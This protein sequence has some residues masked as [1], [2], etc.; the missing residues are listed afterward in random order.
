[1]PKK[2]LIIDDDT[3]IAML[4]KEFFSSEGYQTI[5]ATDGY[6]GVAAAMREKPDL[7]ILD[8]QMPAGGGAGVFERLSTNTFL[9]TTPVIF[10]TSLSKDIMDKMLPQNSM[11]HGYF[12]KP[13]DLE[14]LLK[15]IESIIGKP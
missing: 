8:M 13:A 5:T 9:N 14:A 1:M 15:K 10:S 3:N 6:A 12:Q 11:F 7:I 4:F 2:I